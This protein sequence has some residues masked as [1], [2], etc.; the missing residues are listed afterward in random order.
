[1]ALVGW[2]RSLAATG[3]TDRAIRV[4]RRAITLA[5][6]PEAL[7]GLGNL[8]LALGDERAATGSFETIAAIDRL[9]RSR[10][11]VHDRQIAL[12]YADREIKPRI[13]IDYARAELVTRKDV[14]GY[15]ALA[16]ALYADGRYAAA[17]RASDRALELG[18]RDAKLLYHAGMI[19]AARGD[20]GRAAT[21]LSDALELSPRFDPLGSE[22]ARATLRRLEVPR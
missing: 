3:D 16:W 8:Q 20:D 4:Y 1:V 19:A 14:H 17:S 5:P 2:G 10:G 13:A 18:T 7:A 15:D 12:F 11:G 22:R 9:G 21:L 6:Q